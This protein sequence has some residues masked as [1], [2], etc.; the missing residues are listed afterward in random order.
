[1]TRFAA[2]SAVIVAAIFQLLAIYAAP[3]IR[4]PL[5][6]AALAAP[7]AALLL[8]RA[9][10]RHRLLKIA[11]ANM[12]QG[13]AS[14]DSEGRLVLYN[15]QF[16]AMLGLSPEK[17][18]R[19]RTHRDIID[20]SVR[21]GSYDGLSADDVWRQDATVIALRQTALAYIDLP[22]N[23][24]LAESH[25]PTADGGWVRTYADVTGRRRVEARIIHMA[26]HDALTDLPNR[27]LFRERLELALEGGSD[28]ARPVA[29]LFLDLDRFKEVNDTRGHAVGDRLLVMVAERL[30]RAVRETDT[31][32]RLGGDEFAIIQTEVE[33]ASQTREL[34]ERL[35]ALVSDPYDI[36]DA[37]VSVGASIGITVAPADGA[38]VDEL[39]RS[40]DV[41]LYRAKSAGRGA[42]CFFAANAEKPGD[43]R[44]IAAER[45]QAAE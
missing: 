19:A 39:L 33:E 5:V 22:G 24:T 25:V 41:A 4:L 15:A 40:A 28:R 8:S 21:A 20:L 42:Y 11:V 34:A 3:A 27:A 32:A 17:V 7:L 37:S 2:P 31:V 10:R 45:R 13:L 44:G 14:Y 9:I 12:W 38:G 36:D 29:L 30:R 26:R 43:R 18:R 35:I 16:C 6:F 1:M 23:R